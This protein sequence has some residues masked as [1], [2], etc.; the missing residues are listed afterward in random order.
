MEVTSILIGGEA[1]GD[2]GARKSKE[3]YDKAST[4][5]LVIEPVK[6]GW[7]F[8]ISDCFVKGSNDG[9]KVGN[10]PDSNV[11]DTKGYHRVDCNELNFLVII[12]KTEKLLT[13]LLTC[14]F[15]LQNREL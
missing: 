11:E 8:G 14:L 6:L 10:E 5:I 3:K 4:P 7:L 12:A 9:A 13:I 2:R 15:H 1:V